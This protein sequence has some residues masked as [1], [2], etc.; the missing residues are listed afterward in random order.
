[1]RRINLVLYEEQ[2]EILD[3]FKKE[4]KLKLDDAMNQLILEFSKLKK[5]KKK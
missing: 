2:S 3:N 1:M 5:E 4:N